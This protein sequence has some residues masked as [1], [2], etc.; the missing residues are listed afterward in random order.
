MTLATLILD[1]L[2]A[3]LLLIAVGWIFDGLQARLRR[4]ATDRPADPFADC[5]PWKRYAHGGT[6]FNAANEQSGWI[7]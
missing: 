3:G 5:D 4:R 6:H 2:Y 7:R 1:S